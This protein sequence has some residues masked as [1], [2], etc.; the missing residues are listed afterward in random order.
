[1][2]EILAVLP[3]A[4]ITFMGGL[5]VGITYSEE[6]HVRKLPRWSRKNRRSAK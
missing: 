5:M 3:I 2:Y 1:M 6:E 4:I